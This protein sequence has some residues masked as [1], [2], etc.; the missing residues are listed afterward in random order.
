VHF[1]ARMLAFVV[2]HTCT[3]TA[4]ERMRQWTSTAGKRVV[5]TYEGMHNGLVV[6]KRSDGRR[7]SIRPDLLILSDRKYLED[8]VG[9][10]GQQPAADLEPLSRDKVWKEISPDNPWPDNLPGQRRAAIIN[11]EVKWQH[12][13][14]KYFIIHY[15]RAA[16]AQKVARMGDFYYDYI[17]RE[18]KGLKDLAP[19]KS[20]IYI[21]RKTNQWNQFIRDGGVNLEWASAF[22]S[23]DQM[24]L[25]EISSSRQSEDLLAHEM[26]HVVMNRYFQHSPPIW[27]NEGLAEWYEEFARAEFKGVGK[28]PN[29]VFRENLRT[30]YPLEM[31]LDSQGYPPEELISTFYSTAKYLTAMLRMSKGDEVFIP[32]L[33]DIVTEGAS[34]SEALN[35]RYQ[36]A[37]PGTMVE[38]FEEFSGG[39]PLEIQFGNR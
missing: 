34:A 11:S 6:L 38:P 35:A 20:H 10:G 31:L 25:Q 1:F 5:A 24:F 17:A 22:V 29:M 26:T 33:N 2:L 9:E 18:F 15:E 3:V 19:N 8:L 36:F 4:A 39:D 23:G 32:F 21:F 12:A 30:Y 14:S 7:L 16:F 27:L 28:S 13:E 37:T